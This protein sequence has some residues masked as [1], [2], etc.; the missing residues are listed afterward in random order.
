VSEEDPGPGGSL[1]ALGR[2]K[3]MLSADA[4]VWT[5]DRSAPTVEMSRVRFLTGLGQTPNGFA[6]RL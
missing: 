1:D 2:S 5:N 3:K 6:A 4:Q